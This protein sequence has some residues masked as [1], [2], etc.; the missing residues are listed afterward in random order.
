MHNLA[1]ALL[2]GA[3]VTTDKSSAVNWFVRAAN[4]GYRDSAFDL[5]VLY[6]RGEGVAQNSKIALSWYDTAASLGD[7]Q[8]AK[9]A[10]LLRSDGLNNNRPN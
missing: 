10:A 9:R 3:G 4:M 2:N 1:I 8:A 6:E 5:G 7:G